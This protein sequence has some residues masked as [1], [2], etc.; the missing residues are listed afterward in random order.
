MGSNLFG[1]LPGTETN[2]TS[3]MTGSHVDTVKNGGMYDGTF[4]IAAGVIA[5]KFFEATFRH[6][7]AESGGRFLV[8]RRREPVSDD[9]LGL[10]EHYGP[11][12]C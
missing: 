6:A 8:R 4:G 3:I 11:Q 9:L 10:G 1:K 7:E 12:T 5:L 2:K